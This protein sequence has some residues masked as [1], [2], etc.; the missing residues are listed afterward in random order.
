[1]SAIYILKKELPKFF[2]FLKGRYFVK[3]ATDLNMNF[4]LSNPKYNHVTSI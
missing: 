4:E 3:G 2:T 1:M